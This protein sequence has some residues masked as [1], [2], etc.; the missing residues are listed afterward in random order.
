MEQES[1]TKTGYIKL[2][3]S[4]IE[5][6]WLTNPVLWTFW[7]YCMLKA[8]HKRITQF[9][10]KQQITLQPGQFVFGRKKAAKELKRS[11]REIR[12]CCE[13]LKKL[14]NVTIKTTNKFSI[15]T[16]VNWN[17]YQGFN[18]TNDQQNDQQHANNMPQT[19]SK[20]LKKTNT[21]FE[22]FW[23][24]YPK[25][26]SKGDA[27]KAWAKL[28][29]ANGLYE[30]IMEKLALLKESH[31]WRKDSG[32]YVPYPATWLRAEGWLDEIVKKKGDAEF[33]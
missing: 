22:D 27:S 13:V 29:P 1:P 21:L 17:T 23:K 30:A 3:R 14:Q 25:K 28:E 19:R 4:A 26:R 7:C 12:T 8:S 2:Y 33:I 24:A 9:V 11:E 32:Q 6:G 15:I 31:E 5:K 20:E 18:D 10:G 16:V